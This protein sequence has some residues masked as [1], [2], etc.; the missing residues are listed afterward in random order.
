MTIH[1]EGY[2]S[3]FYVIVFLGVINLGIFNLLPEADLLQNIILVISI[4]IF[5]V[6]LQFFRSPARTIEINDKHIIVDVA[7][8]LLY[9]ERLRNSV[10]LLGISIHNLNNEEKTNIVLPQKSV[11]VQLKFEF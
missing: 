11:S 8:D 1:K 10:R 3:L 7:K 5:L 9:Q 6:V 2:R 4:M